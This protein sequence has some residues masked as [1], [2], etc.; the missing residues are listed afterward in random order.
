MIL[1]DI[2]LVAT[3]ITE[4]LGLDFLTTNLDSP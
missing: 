1:C 3:L 4:D 2:K